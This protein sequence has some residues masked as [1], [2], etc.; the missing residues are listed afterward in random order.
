MAGATGF[1]PAISCLTG[2]YV[3]PSYTTPP[4]T[5]IICYHKF[6][7][8]SNT[9]PQRNIHVSLGGLIG[10]PSP[11]PVGSETTLTFQLTARSSP[12]RSRR[13]CPIDQ[14]LS[15]VQRTRSAGSPFLSTYVI[16]TAYHSSSANVPTDCHLNSITEPELKSGGVSVGDPLSSS[17]PI[18]CG[19]GYSS[20]GASVG[21]MMGVTVGSGDPT[22]VAVTA[23]VIV[24]VA[25]MTGV[26]VTVAVGVAVGGRGV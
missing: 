9:H 2:R 6:S 7:F 24:A 20:A 4:Q 8:W 19:A 5:T 21:V 15:L 11:I 26:K 14:I 17:G 10:T 16:L 23:P 12:R 18:S 13:S 25:V 3:K 1:E 22:G